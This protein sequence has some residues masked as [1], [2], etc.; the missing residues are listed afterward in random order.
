M[1]NPDAFNFVFAFISYI[2]GIAT[3]YYL[4]GVTKDKANLQLNGNIIVLVIVSSIWAIS[5]VMDIVSPSYET[6]PLVHGLMGAIVGFF[7]KQK[8]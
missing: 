6:S 5:M 3:G 2:L 1:I 7:Y 8:K 4:R